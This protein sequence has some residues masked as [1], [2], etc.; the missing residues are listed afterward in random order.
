SHESGPLAKRL[1]ESRNAGVVREGLRDVLGVDWN[2]VCESTSE[3]PE[4]QASAS[5]AVPA[6]AAP[7]AR[8]Y[9]R[10]SGA[11]APSSSAEDI[12]P[13]DD[14]TEPD[15]PE[16]VPVASEPVD[17]EAMLAEAA[18]GELGDPAGRRDPE[19]VAL[20]LLATELGARPLDQR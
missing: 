5:P 12:P 11:P 18:S 10:R 8:R 16:P 15:E 14:P 6:P 4:L 7:A 9:S 13:P 3:Q 17:E 20:E 1:T 19:E 2:V